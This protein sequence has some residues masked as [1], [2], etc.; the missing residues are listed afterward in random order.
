MIEWHIY[1]KRTLENQLNILSKLTL[2]VKKA[3]IYWHL[4]IYKYLFTI[5]LPASDSGIYPIMILVN[6]KGFQ[7]NPFICCTYIYSWMN[8]ILFL[9]LKVTNAHLHDWYKSGLNP[10]L[11]ERAI[12]HLLDSQIYYTVTKFEPRFIWLAKRYTWA[13]ICR[14]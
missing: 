9:Y 14:K 7:L 10:G 13:I 4:M 12:I 6:V 8:W 3:V 11:Y 1:F 2:N 5:T